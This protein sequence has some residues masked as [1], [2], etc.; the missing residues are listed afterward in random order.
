[1]RPHSIIIDARS[2]MKLLLVAIAVFFIAAAQLVSC[3]DVSFA[4][5]SSAVEVSMILIL[6][7][8]DELN[9]LSKLDNVS[10]D[11]NSASK[12][13]CLTKILSAV[14]PRVEKPYSNYKLQADY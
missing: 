11:Q 13:R 6:R 7:K 2:N 4:L 3:Q 14:G 8:R 1:M 10:R 12:L 5:C 9:T